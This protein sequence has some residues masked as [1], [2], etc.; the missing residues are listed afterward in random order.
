[1]NLRINQITFF[2]CS[3]GNNPIKQATSLLS[4]LVFLNLFCFPTFALQTLSQKNNTIYTGNTPIF[5][6]IAVPNYPKGHVYLQNRS[7]TTLAHLVSY[8]KGTNINKQFGQGN[9]L[10]LVN[11]VNSKQSVYMSADGGQLNAI[12]ILYKAGVL[13]ANG[14]NSKAINGLKK[15][16]YQVFQQAK[17]SNVS[18]AKS[19]RKTESLAEY[20]KRLGLS[21]PNQRQRHHSNTGRSSTRSATKVSFSIKNQCRRSVYIFIGTK[22]KYGSGTKSKLSSNSISSRTATVGDQ[23]CIVTERGDAIACRSVSRGMGRVNI[24]PSCSGF[25]R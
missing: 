3:H 25:G 16:R 2:H 11:F 15:Y 24:A 20:R 22:P 18:H 10:F 17:Q 9:N 14:V 1:M 13:T 12:Q 8:G 5:K 19:N 7:G 4:I 6:L 23:L 21:D